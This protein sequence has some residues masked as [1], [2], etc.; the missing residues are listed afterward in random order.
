MQQVQGDVRCSLNASHSGKACDCSCAER[1]H[2]GLQLE[3]NYSSFFGFSDS[4]GCTA[5][6]EIIMNLSEHV[7]LYVVLPR[8]KSMEVPTVNKD[9]EA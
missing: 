1:P 7:G 3:Q 9:C 6:Y 5:Y 2:C 4:G 8:V